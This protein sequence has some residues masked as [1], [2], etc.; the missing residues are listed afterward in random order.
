VF[1]QRGYAADFIALDQLRASGFQSPRNPAD[2]ETT[3]MPD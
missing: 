1:T 2:S 3:R